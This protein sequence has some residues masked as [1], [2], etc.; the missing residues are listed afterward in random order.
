MVGVPW[1]NTARRVNQ[2]RPSAEPSERRMKELGQAR[3]IAAGC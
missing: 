2:H 3:P 1:L